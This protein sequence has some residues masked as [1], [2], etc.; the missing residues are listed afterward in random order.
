MPR[1]TKLRMPKHLFDYDLTKITGMTAAVLISA[2]LSAAIALLDTII[3]VATVFAMLGPMIL[4][5]LYEAHLDR[6][7]LQYLYSSKS[8]GVKLYERALLLHIVLVGNLILIKPGNDGDGVENALERVD[9]FV[10][11]LKRLVSRDSTAETAPEIVE[12]RRSRL[13]KILDFLFNPLREPKLKHAF[14]SDVAVGETRSRLKNMLGMQY[15]FGSAIGAPVVFY[16]GSYIFSLVSVFNSWGDND[17]SH[18]LAF[19]MWW[20]AIPHVAIVSG[21]LLAG[22]NPLTFAGLDYDPGKPEAPPE[23]DPLRQRIN[24]ARK[25][26]LEAAYNSGFQPGWM[27]ERGRLKRNWI[28]KV[29]MDKLDERDNDGG[30]KNKGYLESVTHQNTRTFLIVVGLGLFLEAVPFILAFLTSFY[31]PQVGLSCRSFTFLLYFFCQ[32]WTTTIWGLDFRRPKRHDLI[33]SINFPWRKN[34][35]CPTIFCILMA[36][37]TLGSVFTA[38]AGTFMQIVGVYRNC[39]CDLPMSQWQSGATNIVLSTNTEDA[40]RL[41]RK[42]WLPTG[43][44]ATVVLVVATYVGWWYQKHMKSK[45]YF[46]VDKL[47]GTAD[48]VPLKRAEPVDREKSQNNYPQDAEEQTKPGPK[49]VIETVWGS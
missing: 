7:I 16:T 48:G 13:K 6:K 1:R 9:N 26:G 30:V 19:G 14:E 49:D 24:R 5:G 2:P 34:V 8:K 21:C 36:I 44:T 33:T 23:S 3:W 17:T 18:A 32:V 11:P 35:P 27:W 28:G 38:I 25:W 40:I 22:N 29:F 12:D 47:E 20:T 10:K 41:A 4:S 39:I 15:S 43:I 37:G 45:F 31:T 46:L 42:F